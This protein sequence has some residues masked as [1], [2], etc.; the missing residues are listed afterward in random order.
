[1]EHI[2]PNEV[3][4]LETPTN[5][6]TRQSIPSIFLIHNPFLS[7]PEFHSIDEETDTQCWLLSTGGS[8]GC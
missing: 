4:R 1:M 2:T 6:S 3:P 5:Q 8:V 7:P